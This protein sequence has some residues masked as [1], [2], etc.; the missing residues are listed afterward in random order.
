MAKAERKKN[1]KLRRRVRRTTAIVMLITS[2]IVAAIPVPENAA[3][4]SS[5]GSARANEHNTDGQRYEYGYDVNTQYNA[6]T[7]QAFIFLG[8]F[9]NFADDG[10][11]VLLLESLFLLVAHEAVG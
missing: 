5:S 10:V 4:P 9:A 8:Y 1:R 3:A 2:V 6:E 11:H 7:D